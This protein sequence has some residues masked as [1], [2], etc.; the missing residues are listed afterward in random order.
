MINI[1]MLHG[2][3]LRA[4]T[5]ISPLYIDLDPSL[6]R[7]NR[8]ALKDCVFKV[9]VEQINHDSKTFKCFSQILKNFLSFGM[10]MNFLLIC[11][12]GGDCGPE[13]GG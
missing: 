8:F 11:M 7:V 13:G 12:I 4:F 6:F 1:N 9:S 3:R 2:L 10:F 5:P